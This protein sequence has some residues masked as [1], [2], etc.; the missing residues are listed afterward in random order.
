[1]K[2]SEAA[3]KLNEMLY[4]Q[5]MMDNWAMVLIEAAEA[6]GMLPPLNEQEYHPM[7]NHDRTTV[8]VARQYFTWEPE[9]TEADKEIAKALRNREH[10]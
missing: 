4:G 3:A 6:I 2:K 9:K 1:M 10:Q 8:N 5:P 7:D